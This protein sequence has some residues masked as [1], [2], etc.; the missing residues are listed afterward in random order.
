LNPL[1]D[2]ASGETAW[3]K[4]VY[5]LIENKNPSDYWAASRGKASYYSRRAGVF[6]DT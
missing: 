6:S 1:T 2:Q 3:K 5:S 4:A